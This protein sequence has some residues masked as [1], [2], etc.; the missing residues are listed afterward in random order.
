MK[1]IW[2]ITAMTEEAEHI[3]RLLN[4]KETKKLQHVTFYENDGVVLALAGIWKVQAAIWATLLISEYKVKKLINIG[5]AGNL[6]WNDVKIGDVYLI[7]K[8]VQH[9]M[10]LPFDGSHLDYIKKEIVIPVKW[11]I[12]SSDLK[13]WYYDNWVCLTGDE[14]VDKAERSLEL[15]EKHLGDIAEMEA[16]AVASV[17]R[18]FWLLENTYFI[19]AV[20]DWADTDALADHE[21]NLDFAM[22]NSL[23]ILKK[24]LEI[25]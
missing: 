11:N 15:K 20:S 7:K 1:E 17:A 24:I 6:R 19:K 25:D 12:D 21:N 8:I 23:I 4:L 16:F 18:E 2:I 13:F 22:N 14:F 5:I 10:Y 3:I 9:D